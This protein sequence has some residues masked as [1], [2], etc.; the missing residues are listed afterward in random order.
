M[1]PLAAKGP[2]IDW[3]ALSPLT[4]LIGGAVVVLIVGLLPGRGVRERGVPALTIAAL[5]ATLGMTMLG[6][7]DRVLI[8]LPQAHRISASTYFG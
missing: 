2:H 4:A 3:A 8:T 1:I 7:I 5:G 6:L